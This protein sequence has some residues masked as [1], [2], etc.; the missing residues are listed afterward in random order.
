[1]QNNNKNSVK[2]RILKLK[3]EKNNLGE[4][5]SNENNYE[6]LNDFNKKLVL[7]KNNIN[8]QEIIMKFEYYLNLSIETDNNEKM[9][10]YI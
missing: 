4:S 10:K 8:F 9:E 3:L 5:I 2:R 7:L 1:M 6:N